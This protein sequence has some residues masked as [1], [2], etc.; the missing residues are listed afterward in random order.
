VP[1]RPTVSRGAVR[2]LLIAERERAGLSQT[3][4]ARKLRSKSQPW[5][6]DIESGRKQR[7]D[8]VEFIALAKAIGFDPA[9][10]VRRLQRSR[11]TRQFRKQ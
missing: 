2:A 4:V 1:K 5:I 11:R 3:D 9:K 7:V 8:V 10:A 6:S